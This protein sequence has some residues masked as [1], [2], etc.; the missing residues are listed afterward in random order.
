VVSPDSETEIE[1]VCARCTCA[2]L[3]PTGVCISR[4]RIIPSSRACDIEL[5]LFATGYCELRRANDTPIFFMTISRVNS[6][7]GR[8]AWPSA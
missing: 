8:M 7:H 5:K 6:T 1:D 4:D 3:M 2:P